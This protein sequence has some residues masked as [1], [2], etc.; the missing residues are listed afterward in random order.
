MPLIKRITADIFEL[1][2][3]ADY[4]VNLVNLLGAPGRGLAL[5]F[6]K[7]ISDDLFFN[8][9]REACRSKELRIGS[10]QILENTG[11]RWGAINFPT[12]RHYA[13]Q[14]DIE[15]IR[16]SLSALRD[17]LV[18]EQY[19]R[20]SIVMPMAGTGLGGRGYDEVY[21]M[22]IDY[23]GDIK[24]TVFLCMAPEKTEMRPNYLTIAGPVTY[25][26]NDEEKAKIDW[27]VDK[28][29]ESWGV[30]INDY[31]GI[32]SGGM[33][34]VDTYIGGVEFRENEQDT[35]V[36]RKTGKIPLVIKPN[37]HRNGVGSNLYQG[38]LLCEAGDDIILL[39]PKGHNNN[40]LSAMQAWID[41]D[42][43]KRERE[44]RFP[45]RVAIY[46]DKTKSTV[47]ESI[48]IPVTEADMPY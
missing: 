31:E 14:S 1:E 12:K 33:P 19:N 27:V 5:E 43:E 47:S 7:R 40:R 45:K 10:V 42:F 8:P 44:G 15:D 17:V 41:S 9:Y 30:S 3:V 4:M 38:N 2:D 21:P 28:V 39:K 32:I 22:M 18:H 6:R 26:L 46:G 37:I 48:A 13:D 20:C 25:G 36:F 29:L 16:R 34:G 35:Y 24:S 11:H 23:L